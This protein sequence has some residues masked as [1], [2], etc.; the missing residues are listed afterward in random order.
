MMIRYLVVLAFYLSSGWAQS[1]VFIDIANDQLLNFVHDHGGTGEKYYME[2]MG[3][4]VCLFDYDNDGD[5]DAYFLQGA[6]LPGWNKKIILET[7]CTEMME[8][9]GRM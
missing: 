9:N 8:K 3:S 2:T 7:S 1:L 6:P 5:L 4:G